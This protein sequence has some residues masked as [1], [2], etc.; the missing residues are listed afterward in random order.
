MA[1]VKKVYRGTFSLRNCEQQPA[2]EV[3][4]QE[5]LAKSGHTAVEESPNFS[6]TH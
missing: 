1:A 3:A 5:D 6:N 2:V 4:G